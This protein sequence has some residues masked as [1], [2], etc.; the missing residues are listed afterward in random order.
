MATLENLPDDQR[1]VLQLVLQRGR[2]YDE[3]ARLLSIDRAAVRQ[4][5]LHAFDALGPQ[6]GVADQR[7]ALI[8]DYLLGQLPPAVSQEVR[9]RLA[10]S[11]SER[12]WARVLASELAPLA[13]K[14]FPEIPT[15]ITPAAEPTAEPAPAAVAAAEPAAKP[16]RPRESVLLRRRR[17]KQAAEA[18]PSPQAGPP[19]GAAA[20]PAAA[21]ERRSS[22]L[23]GAILIALG[24]LVIAALV[25][26][27]VGRGGSAK[28]HA[29]TATSS[30][31]SA[32]TSASAAPTST[33]SGS[34]A[35]A[36]VVA[37]VNLR[38]TT[39]GSK[40]VGIAEVLKEGSA[41]GIAIVAQN[42]PPNSTKP[43]NA[44]AVWLYNSTRDAR[45]LGFVNPGVGRSGKLSTAGGLPPNASR[46]KRLIVTVETVAHPKA[47][48][49]IILAGP[50][51]GL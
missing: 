49:T 41:D 10:R 1:A 21:Q 22:R 34:T 47:P 6:T 3:I 13:S 20:T 25:V 46:Y 4:R 30:P 44:Y 14:P 29:P 23:G 9:D 45:F 38:P 26:F 2:G 5:A 50:L 35:G 31:A 15:E 33:T 42:V 43:P 12:A 17:R 40:A 11:P 32:S 7:R 24:L 51:S 28:P 37:Q 19:A 48:G 18:E 39:K 27:V 8:T 36:H 16:K